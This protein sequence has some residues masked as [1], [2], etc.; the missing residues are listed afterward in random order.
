MHFKTLSSAVMQF[1]L[2]IC[3]SAPAAAAEINTGA[4]T[5]APMAEG[6]YAVEPNFVI[7]AAASDEDIQKFRCN[8]VSEEE[9]GMFDQMVGWTISRAYLEVAE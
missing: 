5:L 3:H 6:I 7:E 4:V 8:F 1:A 9:D 2:V